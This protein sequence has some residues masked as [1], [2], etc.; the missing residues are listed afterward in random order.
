MRLL[1]L[2]FR[3]SWQWLRTRKL[4]ARI[5]PSPSRVVP[6]GDWGETLG[7]RRPGTPSIRLPPSLP[8]VHT[9]EQSPFGAGGGGVPS[10]PAR[11]AAA[12]GV[13]AGRRRCAGGGRGGG[14]SRS[15]GG[16]AGSWCCVEGSVGWRASGAA[17]VPSVDLARQEAGGSG[18]ARLRPDPAGAV[19]GVPAGGAG[20]WVGLVWGPAGG[21]LPASA[22]GALRAPRLGRA[23][24]AWCWF[25]R[26]SAWPSRWRGSGLLGRRWGGAAASVG[27]GRSGA[28]VAAR[29]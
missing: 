24:A 14:A 18:L 16:V 4:D 21:W 8:S 19:A 11:V 22:G 10:S 25:R 26:G 13:V 1:F 29:I 27:S 12:R 20:R 2:T 15:G 3:H 7:R 6:A 5:H 23:A 17:A 28:A 9:V